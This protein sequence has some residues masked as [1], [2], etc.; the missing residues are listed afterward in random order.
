[1]IRR[2][3]TV[4]PGEGTHGPQP[5]WRVGA[6]LMRCLGL[7]RPERARIWREGRVTVNGGPV[8]A[9]HVHCF[10]GDVLEAWYPEPSSSVQPEPHLPLRV[11]YEDAWLLAV[12]KPA[13]QLSH[14]ARSE[15]HGTVANA[16]AARYRHTRAGTDVA[17]DDEAPGPPQPVRPVHRL[18]RDTSG[19]LLFARDAGTARAI[20]RQ[21]ARGRIGRQ[22]LALVAGS[23][24]PS[25][26]I[27]LLL[28][29]EPDHRT[30]QRT[31]DRPPAERTAKAYPARTSFR[32]I[33]RG[34][35]AALVCA[36]LHTGRTHQVRAH[37]T[38]IGYPLLGDDLYGGPS[39]P[40]LAGQALHAW[41]LRFSHPATGVGTTI[42]AP[43]SAPFR[44]AA[45]AA[46][47]ASRPS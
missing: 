5:V 43:P 37:F 13:G 6:V 23:P 26:E 4:V 9:Q 38:A 1:V 16:V 46:L 20:T 25:G 31:Y 42:V 45:K 30:R 27:D 44:A 15:Q 39:C 22:Y 8:T 28:G 19:V 29:P 14:P 33:Q 12:D 10:P 24:P 17:V 35:E 11:L 36:T 21:R 47:G 7:S 3:Q 40:G 18:D 32:V 2:F 34:S 41:R